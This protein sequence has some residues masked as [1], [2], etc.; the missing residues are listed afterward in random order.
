MFLV[1]QTHAIWGFEY[2]LRNNISLPMP[3][4]ISVPT[5]DMGLSLINNRFSGTPDMSIRHGLVGIPESII[6]FRYCATTGI[7]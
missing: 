4:S 7:H 6:I 5:L 1:L 3:F 2:I